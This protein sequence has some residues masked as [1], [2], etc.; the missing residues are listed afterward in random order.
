MYCISFHFLLLIISFRTFVLHLLLLRGCNKNYRVHCK[1]PA[2]VG[3]NACTGL[4]CGNGTVGCC[5]RHCWLLCGAPLAVVCGTVAV[6]CSTVGCCVRH[7]WL[8][9]AALLAVACGTVVCCV[10]HCY[11]QCAAVFYF[12]FNLTVV[13]PSPCHTI[14]DIED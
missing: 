10:R 5:V 3:N 1:L 2:S 8:L 9:C 14:Q 7:C 6:V 11:L 4:W 12:V 13:L